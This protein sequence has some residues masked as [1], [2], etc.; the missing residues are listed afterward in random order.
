M[1]KLRWTGGTFTDGARGFRTS[2]GVHEFDEP[3]R[4]EEYLDHR[5]GDWERVEESA[6]ED[7][8]ADEDTGD[9]DP[10]TAEADADPKAEADDV[11]TPTDP[12][13][14]DP[15][16]LTVTEIE[17]ELAERDLSEADLLAVYSAEREAEDRTTAVEAIDAALDEL[18]G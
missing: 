12:P 16:D 5:S 3:E 8:T 4:V 2:G 14:F 13:P 11:V 7:E 15:T 9:E 6:D 10:D 1:A 17:D 18:E